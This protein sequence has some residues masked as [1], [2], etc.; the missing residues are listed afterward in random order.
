MNFVKEKDTPVVLY[1]YK[2]VLF[3]NIDEKGC[4]FPR[5]LVRF[6]ILVFQQFRS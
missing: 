6:V 5:I 2:M 1:I 3:L 4:V